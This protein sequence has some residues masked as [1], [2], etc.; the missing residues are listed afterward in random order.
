M[1]QCLPARVVTTQTR[2]SVTW[3][4]RGWQLVAESA[5]VVVVVVAVL[6]VVLCR[7]DLQRWSANEQTATKRVVNELKEILRKKFVSTLDIT[8][9]MLLHFDGSR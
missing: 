1:S 3:Q 5:V 6:V 4:G 8:Y 7:Q 2:S 9:L